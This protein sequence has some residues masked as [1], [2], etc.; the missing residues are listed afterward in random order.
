L[1]GAKDIHTWDVAIFQN[2]L[3]IQLEKAKAENYR[4]QNKPYMASA[5]EKNV[6][7]LTDALATR[8]AELDKS[9]ERRKEIDT[10]LK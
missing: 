3:D 1:V 6:Q 4:A 8:Q 10:L 7:L 5:S 9:T 2:K